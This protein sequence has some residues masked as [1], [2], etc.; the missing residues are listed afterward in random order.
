MNEFEDLKDMKE[1]WIEL[2]QRVANLEEENRRLMRHVTGNKYKTAQ[3]KL[4]RK[5][6]T[7]III[8]FIMI[9]YVFF[10][11]MFNPFGVEKYKIPVLIYW[12]LFFLGEAG[13][14]FYLRTKVLEIDIYNSSVREST[15][16]AAHNWKIHKLAVAFGLPVAIGAVVLFALFMNA[17]TF[18]IIGMIVGAVVGLSIG[19]MQLRKFWDYYRLLQTKDS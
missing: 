12:T 4:V 19:V 14:D 2:N 9:V 13:I 5:Y 16:Q 1:M 3:E 7:F 8:A 11:V 18:V 10:I 6:T 15:R 17:D